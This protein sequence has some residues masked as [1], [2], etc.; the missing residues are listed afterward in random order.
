[1]LTFRILVRRMV[2][3][4]K[5]ETRGWNWDFCNTIVERTGQ[6]RK[7]CIQIKFVEISFDVT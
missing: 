3:D 4:I 7:D 6:S 1:M 2:F 5:Y